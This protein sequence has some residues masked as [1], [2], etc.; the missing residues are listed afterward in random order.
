MGASCSNAAAAYD[1]WLHYKQAEFL[2]FYLIPCVVII[3]V[4]SRVVHCLWAKNPQLAERTLFSSIVSNSI[5]FSDSKRLKVD[6]KNDSLKTRM[7]VIKMLVACVAVYFI[8][9]SP[10]QI[11]FLAK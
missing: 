10:I 7:S 11:V 8:C 1:W 2:A 5:R 4:Y 3:F 9:Y 6:K